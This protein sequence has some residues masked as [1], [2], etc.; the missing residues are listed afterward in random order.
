MIEK[1]FPLLEKVPFLYHT[2]YWS[3]FKYLKQ[4]NKCIVSK[5]NIEWLILQLTGVRVNLY[6]YDYLEE[7][8]DYDLSYL[9]PDD[10]VLNIGAGAGL[11][12]LL[13]ASICRHVY[14]IE[15]ILTDVLLKNLQQSKFKDKISLLNYAFGRDGYTTCSYWDRQVKVRS[16]SLQTILNELDPSPTY[17]KCDCEGCEFEGFMSCQ[18]F[19][20]VRFIELEY[21]TNTKQKLSELITHLRQNGFSVKIV[22]KIPIEE[23]KYIGILYASR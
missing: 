12:A 3:L 8:Y 19:K 9:K 7:L 20:T 15:P 16:K 5:S 10:V 11:Y 4:K 22:D 6:E 1:I 18:D 13:S 2:F 14:V 23:F 17:I 21:H